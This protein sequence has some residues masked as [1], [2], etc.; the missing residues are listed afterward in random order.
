MERTPLFIGLTREVSFAGLPIM[1]LVVLIATVM[2][3]FI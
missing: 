3:G 2:L 1:Y